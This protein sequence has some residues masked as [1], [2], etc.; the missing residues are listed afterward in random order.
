MLDDYVRMKAGGIVQ[1]SQSRYD[2]VV[3]V[4]SSAVAN[5]QD[6]MA[7]RSDHTFGS[8]A[9]EFIQSATAAM[10]V[11]EFLKAQ[12]NMDL[13]GNDPRAKKLYNDIIKSGIEDV[14]YND[15]RWK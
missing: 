9:H 2:P 15:K 10:K 1:R 7:P 13:F 12:D 6:P 5:A 14:L 8:Y 3:G 11:L 4:V